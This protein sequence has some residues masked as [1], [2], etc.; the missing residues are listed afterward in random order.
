MGEAIKHEQKNWGGLLGRCFWLPWKIGRRMM[1]CG[2]VSLLVAV[3]G[4]AGHLAESA[5][6]QWAH[7]TLPGVWI[8]KSRWLQLLA[9]SQLTQ[10]CAN[11]CRS[12]VSCSS[13]GGCW[14]VVCAR[15]NFL[16]LICI[17]KCVCVRVSF[18]QSSRAYVS[19]GMRPE[20]QMSWT[21]PS[22]SGIRD[23]PGESREK[24]GH[25]SLT[26]RQRR[27]QHLQ[28]QW[29]SALWSNKTLQLHFQQPSPSFG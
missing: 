12:V 15:V 3:V 22:Y 16:G 28:V 7:A 14:K 18:P 29:A 13:L 21:C 1:R 8:A 19:W 27:Q 9:G 2:R 17:I 10:E 26:H 5:R 24:L 25:T 20:K 23:A 11:L 4:G 6:T